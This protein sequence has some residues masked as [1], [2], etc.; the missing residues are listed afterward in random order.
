[1][2]NN[3]AANKMEKII[4]IWKLSQKS[5]SKKRKLSIVSLCIYIYILIGVGVSSL[6]FWPY[7]YPQRIKRMNNKSA[8]DCCRLNDCKRNLH[9][10]ETRESDKKKVT[11]IENWWF[12][13]SLYRK[14][15]VSRVER[16][17]NLRSSTSCRYTT[18]N[19]RL[20]SRNANKI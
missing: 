3:E 19:Y 6:L 7:S 2:N 16:E 20:L 4:A 13:H 17:L 5:S 15:I 10:C 11:D 18:R 1:M 14:C 12:L 9:S 8:R